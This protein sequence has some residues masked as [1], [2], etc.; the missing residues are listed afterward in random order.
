MANYIMKPDRQCLH[1]ILDK[2]LLPAMR[3]HSGDSIEITTLEADWRLECPSEKDT[4]SKSFPRISGHDDGH[5]LCGPIYVEGAKAG[6]SLK[7]SIDE[8]IPESWGWSCVGIGDRD[9]LERLGFYGKKD[10]QVWKIDYEKKKCYNGRGICVPLDPFPGVVAVAPEGSFPVKTHIPGKHGG[11]LDCK[12]L[13]TG[14]TIYLP[15]FHDGALFSIGDGHAVQGDGESGGT[16]IECPFQKIKVTLSVE[17]LLLESPVVCTP[18]KWI[19]FGFAQDLTAAAYEALRNMRILLKKLAN[20]QDKD[21]MTIC[22]IS[23]DIRVTQ[24]V[25][26]IRGVHVCMPYSFIESLKTR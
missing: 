21:A 17:E 18:T 16:A 14:S 6:M 26:G 1:G 22:S 5:A 25:N 12:E 11:N 19:T 24:I 15:V 23:A 7:I 20:I 8:I 13:R 3:V 2:N 4:I 9:H 10:F